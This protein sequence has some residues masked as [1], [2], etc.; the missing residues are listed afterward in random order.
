MLFNVHNTPTTIAKT[1]NGVL[2]TEPVDERHCCPIYLEWRKHDG[3]N[4]AKDDIIDLHWIH[5]R[6][7]W[8][9]K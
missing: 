4:A 3:V 9:E 1:F 6:E 5:T 8:A 2:S 7:R